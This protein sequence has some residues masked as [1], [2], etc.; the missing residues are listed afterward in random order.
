MILGRIADDL[1]FEALVFQEYVTSRDD[2]EFA[3]RLE[4]VGDALAGARASYL[5]G[6]DRVDAL[7]AAA[8]AA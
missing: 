1:D 7:T 6:R 3:D 2:T 5:E 8:E 4:A